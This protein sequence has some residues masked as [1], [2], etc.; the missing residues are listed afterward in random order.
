MNKLRKNIK[1]CTNLLQSFQINYNSKVGPKTNAL[2][3][4]INTLLP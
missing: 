3:S 1:S 4:Q 2:I